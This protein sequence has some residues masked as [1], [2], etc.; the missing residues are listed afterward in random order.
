MSTITRRIMDRSRILS[1][2]Y[3]KHDAQRLDGPPKPSQ[4][5]FEQ[6][7]IDIMAYLLADGQS[8]KVYNHHDMGGMVVEYKI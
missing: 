7:M 2:I 4:A 1:I 8:V 6:A 5:D 3:H